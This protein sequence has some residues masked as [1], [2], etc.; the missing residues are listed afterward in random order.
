MTAQMSQKTAQMSQPT[1]RRHSADIT[2]DKERQ[3]RRKIFLKQAR[4]AL[5]YGQAY[6]GMRTRWKG[7]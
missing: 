3:K 5:A 7:F 4:A 1:S 6:D 2:D